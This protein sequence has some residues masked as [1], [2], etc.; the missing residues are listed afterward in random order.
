M[1]AI[2]RKEFLEK[3]EKMVEQKICM[4]VE[5]RILA[6]ILFGKISYKVQYDFFTLKDITNDNYIGFNLNQINFMGVEEQKVVFI[7][8]DPKDTKIEIE[9]NY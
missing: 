1:Q 9:M 8:D 4:K 6:K 3:L 7:L 5:G 2:T